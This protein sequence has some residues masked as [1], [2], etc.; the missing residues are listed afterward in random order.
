[1][2]FSDH[3]V[4]SQ[5]KRYMYMLMY[6]ILCFWKGIFP[7]IKP[8]ENLPLSCLSTARAHL[9]MLSLLVLNMGY[10]WVLWR[11]LYSRSEHLDMQFCIKGPWL[12]AICTCV[13]YTKNNP[14]DSNYCLI[15]SQLLSQFYVFPYLCLFCV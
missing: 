15:V 1:M 11:S 3:S 4:S 7:K 8:P 14:T 6:V 12:Y 2:S 10:G 5:G 13:Q 9:Y